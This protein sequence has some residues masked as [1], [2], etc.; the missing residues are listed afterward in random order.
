METSKKKLVRLNVDVE[1]DFKAEIKITAAKL[2]ITMKE[3]LEEALK[4]WIAKQKKVS[5]AS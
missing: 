5:S 1:R 2:G 3:A 4:D